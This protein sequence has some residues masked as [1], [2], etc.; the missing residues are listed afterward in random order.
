ML[1]CVVSRYIVWCIYNK[2]T[3]QNF[4]SYIEADHAIANMN[5]LPMFPRYIMLTIVSSLSTTI[6]NAVVCTLHNFLWSKARFMHTNTVTGSHSCA[7][8]TTHTPCVHL[9]E[10]IL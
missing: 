10:N 6:S 7:D 9:V 3:T 4:L 5:E 2:F 1:V 8:K